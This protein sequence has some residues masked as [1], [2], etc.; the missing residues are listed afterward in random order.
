MFSRF[1]HKL[2]EKRGIER[3]P[4]TERHSS[5]TT[6]DYLKMGVLWFSTSITA[7]NVA[8]GMYGPL[9]YSLSFVDSALC[10]TFGS[11]L[12]AAGVAYMATFGPLSG[13]RTMVS[14]DDL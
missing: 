7:N 4:E 6:A 11:F 3:V 8:V 12:G 14:D 10:A 1:T 13:N 5:V 2:L 9:G